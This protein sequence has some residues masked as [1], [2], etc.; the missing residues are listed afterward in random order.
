MPAGVPRGPRARR[1]PA[2]GPRRGPRRP[3]GRR[4]RRAARP[5]PWGPTDWARVRWDGDQLAIRLGDAHVLFTT[6]R[7]GVSEG[8]FAS[9]NLGERTDDDPAAVAAQPRAALRELGRRRDARAVPR[10]TAATSSRPTPPTRSDREADGIG[11]RVAGRRRRSSSPP[12]A[13][14][15]RSPAPAAWRCCTRAGAASPAACSTRASRR[16][17]T[18]ARR[19]GA[20]RDRPGRRGCCYEVGDEVHE[21]LRRERARAG[22]NAR[23]ARR[24]RATRLRR[25]AS[26]R[27]TT[28]AVHDLRRALLLHRRDRGVT[29]RQAGVAW[30]ELI[31]GSTPRV[32]EPRA[33]RA[34]EHRRAPGATPRDV[35]I[36]AADQVRR[37]R[38]ARR[39]RRGRGRA[40]GREPRAGARGQARRARRAFDLGLHR[41]PAEPQGQA[42]RCRS[43]A[44]PLR[45]AATPCCAQLERHARPADD[46]GPGRG[47]R[48]RR[49]GQERAS[50]P[51]SSAP[52]SSAAPVARRSA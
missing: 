39:A 32:R 6:R 24:S 29:G 10:C 23:P 50:R 44:D 28:P 11:D 18:S 51:P 2:G 37:R 33:G 31:P 9:L 38:G 4:P 16:C 7:G 26:R 8:P 5:S 49:G 1:A 41:P 46:R 25:R 48:R 34:S 27:S 21:A 43:C 12:T 36:L 20:R 19:R 35:E 45:R 17:A 13:C 3:G 14:R 15:S 22:R 42:D 40:G 52:S 30:R 47:Q